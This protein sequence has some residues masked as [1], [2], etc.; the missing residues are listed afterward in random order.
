[1]FGGI[2]M[3]IVDKQ[4]DDGWGNFILAPKTDNYWKDI[5]TKVMYVGNR[6]GEYVIGSVWNTYS[7]SDFEWNAGF[8]EGGSSLRVVGFLR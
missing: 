8:G 5:I 2:L 3:G 1:M 6:T 7:G 4:Y